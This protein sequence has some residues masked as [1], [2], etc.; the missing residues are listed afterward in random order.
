VR[1]TDS[2]HVPEEI[3]RRGIPVALLDPVLEDPQQLLRV[4]EGVIHGSQQ[5]NNVPISLLDS[6]L[7]G[8]YS[9]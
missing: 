7:G 6:V 9:R 4:L 3:K 1:F 8:S 5:L 2:R